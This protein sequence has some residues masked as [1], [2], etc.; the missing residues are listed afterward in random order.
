MQYLEDTNSLMNI[1]H[2]YK[3]QKPISFHER[4][5]YN[6]NDILSQ[7]NGPLS[8]QKKKKLLNMVN[9]SADFR[10]KDDKISFINYINNPEEKK[11]TMPK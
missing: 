10:G 8:L 3:I 1:Q 6:K 5:K 11:F 9:N 7:S 2:R 4:F